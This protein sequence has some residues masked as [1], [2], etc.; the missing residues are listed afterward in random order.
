MAGVAGAELELGAGCWLLGAW[1]GRERES[2]N[3]RGRARCRQREAQRKGW[4]DGRSKES[5]KD[6]RAARNPRRRDRT[7]Y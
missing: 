4:N 5:V 2:A 3:E 7:E 1:R 6:S